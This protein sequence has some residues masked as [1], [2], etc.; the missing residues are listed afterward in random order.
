MNK[1]KVKNSKL[2]YKSHVKRNNLKNMQCYAGKLAKMLLT[3]EK[4]GD[5]MIS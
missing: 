1:I 5:R 2:I 4:I 3:N